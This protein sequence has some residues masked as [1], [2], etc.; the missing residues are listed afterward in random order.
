MT[1]AYLRQCLQFLA[2]QQE[3]VH[4]HDVVCEGSILPLHSTSWVSI[5]SRQRARTLHGFPPPYLQSERL[6]R[7][8]FSGGAAVSGTLRFFLS[9]SGKCV[10]GKTV[11]A[12]A[13]ALPQ[14]LRP[15]GRTFAGEP[16]PALPSARYTPGGT[17][18]ASSRPGLPGIRHTGRRWPGPPPG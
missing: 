16:I 5:H 12:K 3:L 15:G 18:P 1:F 7:T 4:F 11:P 14:A 10:S 8:Q 6:R 13:P 2:T 17:D 9:R